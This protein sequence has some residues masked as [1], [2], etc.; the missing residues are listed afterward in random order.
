MVAHI[1]S[2][3]GVYDQGNEWGEG[4]HTGFSENGLERVKQT[5]VCCHGPLSSSGRSVGEIRENW[6][7]AGQVTGGLVERGGEAGA[8]ER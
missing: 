7:K 6:D 1:H 5:G 8:A 4:G 3:R 2:Q